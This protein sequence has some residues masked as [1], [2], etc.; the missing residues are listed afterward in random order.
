MRFLRAWLESEFGEESAGAT[1]LNPRDY[2]T[3][4]NKLLVILV[5]TLTYC[6]SIQVQDDPPIAQGQEQLRLP[7]ERKAQQLE[8][9]HFFGPKLPQPVPI[10]AA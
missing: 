4:A 8:T 10:P 5:R 6:L 7:G 3:Y 2:T 9:T 1:E